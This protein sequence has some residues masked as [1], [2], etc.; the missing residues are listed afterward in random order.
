LLILIAAQ[1]AQSPV[2]TVDQAVEIALKDA[3][4]VRSTEIVQRRAEDLVNL[5][6]TAAGLNVS[7]QGSYTRIEQW[8]VKRDAFGGG[9]GPQPDTGTFSLNVSQIIDV[10]GAVRRAVQQ[11]RLQRDAAALTVDAQKNIIRSLVRFQCYAVLQ[12]QQAVA[13]QEAQLNAAKERLA[14]GEVR[15]RNDAI[16]RF[17]V[18][19]LETDVRRSEQALVDARLNAR[20]SKQ[21]LNNLL[22]RDIETP[23]ELAAVE[24]QALPAEAPDALVELALKTRPDLK[25]AET[26]VK[27]LNEAVAR[28]RLGKAPQVVAGISHKETLTALGPGQARGTTAGVLTVTLPLFDSDLTA[29]RVRSARKDV[30]QAQIQLDQLKLAAALEV[31]Q[32]LSRLA[33]ANEA[34]LTALKTEELAR[35]GLRLAQ[36]RYDESV[37]ILVDVTTAQAQLTS[38]SLSASIARF[39]ALTALAELNRALGADTLETRP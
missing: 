36:L 37:G 28:E 15:F 27:A 31:R 35:E 30:E 12:S 16:P 8:A 29:N 4:A 33:S 18:I 25:A 13:I 19:R 21:S 32:A 2:L 17:D 26:T 9:F 6:K 7:L 14:K 23:F 22:A 1:A 20:L 3:F 10:S 5:A 39:S 11:A 24:G 34:L 38:A